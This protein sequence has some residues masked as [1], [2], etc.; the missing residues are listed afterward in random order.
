MSHTLQES[1]KL[2]HIELAMSA[3]TPRADVDS[4]FFYEPLFGTH[5]TDETD[6]SLSFL[7]KKLKAPLWV[8][9]MTGGVGPARHINQN[10]A[11]VCAQFGLG[12]GST[13]S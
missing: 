2:D 1:R 5:P 8:S 10:L 7:G 3:Q 12:L 11:R 13:L 4:R 6:L 9:S